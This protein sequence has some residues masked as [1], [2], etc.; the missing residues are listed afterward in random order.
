MK[1]HTAKVR[2]FSHERQNRM[3]KFYKLILFFFIAI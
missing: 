3:L 2:L 1:N